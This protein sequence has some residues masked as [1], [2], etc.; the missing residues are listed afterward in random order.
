MK[1]LHVKNVS[2][3]IIDKN[4]NSVEDVL[5]MDSTLAEALVILAIPKVV[6]LQIAA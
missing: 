4:E 2:T 1:I 6:E 3:F 5:G